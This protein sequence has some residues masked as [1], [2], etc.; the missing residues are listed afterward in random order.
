MDERTAAAVMDLL[1]GLDAVAA[2]RIGAD[3]RLVSAQGFLAGLIAADAGASFRSPAWAQLVAARAA[4]SAPAFRGPLAFADARGNEHVVHGVIWRL[5]AGFLLLAERGADDIE[6]LSKATVKLSNDLAAARREL[7]GAS[8]AAPER[9]EPARAASFVDRATG[10]GNRRAFHQALANEVLRA[11]RYGGPLCLVLAAIDGLDELAAH[12]GGERAEDIVRGFS[13]VVR[14]E[15][16]Q[17]D[18]ACRSG[19]NEFALLLTQT[20]PERAARAIERIRL[21]FAAASPGIAGTTVT[22][23]FGSV[24]WR[25]GEDAGSLV[26][27]A[28]EA[29]G[30]ARKAGGD[31]V[32][33]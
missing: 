17:T 32:S 16:R 29:L 20:P 30:A 8:R 12:F 25:K 10:L 19:D 15:T 28:R 31:G 22:A 1:A 2:A 27:R 11:D 26:D 33:G 24:D 14:N 21:A 5:E 3:G 18:H 13:R 23:S 4:H 6:H 9:E 7:A